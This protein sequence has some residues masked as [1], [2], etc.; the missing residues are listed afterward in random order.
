MENKKRISWT[1]LDEHFNGTSWN[2]FVGCEKISS[3]VKIVMH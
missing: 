1:L 3:V 2:P